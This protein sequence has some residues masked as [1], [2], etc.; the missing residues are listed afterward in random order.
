LKI[1]RIDFYPDDWIAGTLCLGHE[2][3]S[4]YISVCVAIWSQGGPADVKFVRQICPGPHFKRALDRLVEKG[5]VT[6]IESMDGPKVA[7]KRA[8]SE[9]ERARK[10]TESDPKSA[11]NQPQSGPG[12][13]PKYRNGN[14]LAYPRARAGAV[15]Q[16]TTIN[17][18]PSLKGDFENGNWKKAETAIARQHL[19]NH[20]PG[21][22]CSTC[23]S[24]PCDECEAKREARRE[25]HRQKLAQM[26]GQPDGSQQERQPE[27]TPD[28]P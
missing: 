14:G 27:A 15:Q 7:Q 5:K 3:R 25:H 28:R 17:H 2:E 11:R 12:E 6:L 18:Q 9:L 19:L 8:E 4:V 22:Q 13:A 23:D 21:C 10:R 26:A 1:R 16:P 24:C 20:G